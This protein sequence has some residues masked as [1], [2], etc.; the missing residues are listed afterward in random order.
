MG[1]EVPNELREP[2]R[3]LMLGDRERLCMYADASEMEERVA[4]TSM[5]PCVAW[6]SAGMLREPD[7]EPTAR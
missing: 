4:G 7:W 6:P 5:A 3:S 2:R 1:R